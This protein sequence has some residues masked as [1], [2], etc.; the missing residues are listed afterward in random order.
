M[1]MKVLFKMGCLYDWLHFASFY[2]TVLIFLVSILKSAVQSKI[3]QF[4]PPL[5]INIGGEKKTI[6]FSTILPLNFL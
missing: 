2:A 4:L 3:K 1:L 5:T 6:Y